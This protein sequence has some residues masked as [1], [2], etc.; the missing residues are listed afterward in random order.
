M[1]Q[2]KLKGLNVLV[3]EELLCFVTIL[4][5]SSGLRIARDALW[6]PLQVTRLSKAAGL[7]YHLIH[8]SAGKSWGPSKVLIQQ[9]QEDQRGVAIFP[10]SDSKTKGRTAVGGRCPFH[11]NSPPLPIYKL[12]RPCLSL[13]PQDDLEELPGQPLTLASLLHQS[14][15]QMPLS[16]SRAFLEV[17]KGVESWSWLPHS[18]DT[19]LLQAKSHQLANLAKE[20]SLLLPQES[21]GLFG[22]KSQLWLPWEVNLAWASESLFSNRSFMTPM[23]AMDAWSQ[24]NAP[25]CTKLGGL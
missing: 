10:R 21:K 20:P 11:P 12:S 16:F 3:A 2:S 18:G 19:W 14:S 5:K 23:E 7:S 6:K 17:S 4:L 13:F 15:S 25:K 8:T 22:P 1:R 24:K 9:G